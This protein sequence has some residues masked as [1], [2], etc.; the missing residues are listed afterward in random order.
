MRPFRAILLTLAVLLGLCSNTSAA[1]RKDSWLGPD[2]L[3]PALRKAAKDDIVVAILYQ[4]ADGWAWGRAKFENMSGMGGMLKVRAYSSHF[5][6]EVNEL[7]N[8]VTAMWIPSM[9]FT[10]GE[11]NLIA[12]IRH[13]S[14]S[15]EWGA[16]IA[17]AKGVMKWKKRARKNLDKAEKQAAEG[18]FAP[19]FKTLGKVESE[20]KKWTAKIRKSYVPR[21]DSSI[22]RR[23]GD[24]ELSEEER[25]RLQ[26]RRIK[27]IQMFFHE[28]IKQL[29]KTAEENVEKAYKRAEELLYGGS[30]KDAM[31]TLRPLLTCSIDEPTD[32]RI[33][34][35]KERILEAIRTGVAPKREGQQEAEPE[36][37][38]DEKPKESD[39]PAT[40]EEDK[41]DQDNKDEKDE[42][43]KEAT[44][45]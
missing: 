32:A 28:R 24:P 16:S 22:A 9:L 15:R 34:Q 27:T 29:R 33:K 44:P 45:G 36:E 30:P 13:D 8:Q 6:K 5:V 12:Y 35:L 11:G 10:D 20:D 7:W 17:Q 25:D 3:I 1:G 2:K 23:L 18:P 41:K 26:K 40:E 31:A 39:T 4:D 14:N 42:Q 43:E 38:S 19:V 21:P 37:T